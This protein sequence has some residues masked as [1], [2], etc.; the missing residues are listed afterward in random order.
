MVMVLPDLRAASEGEYYNTAAV[1]RRRRLPARQVPQAPHPAPA[2][3]LGEVLL[4]P[5]QP[6]LPGLRHRGRPG[7]RLH[8]LR[9][10]LPRGLARARPERRADRLQ[11]VGHQARP[12]QPAVEAR[13]ARR[14]RREPVLRRARTTGSAARRRVRRRRRTSTARATSSTPR[15]TSSAR[16]RPTRQG[17]DRVRDLDL[18]QIRR[19]ATTGSSTATA[20]RTPTRHR[21]LTPPRSRDTTCRPRSS[22]AARSSR[23]PALALRTSSSTARR[24]PRCS[25]PARP[26]S[27]RTSTAIADTSSTRPAST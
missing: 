23:P 26:C 5:R 25:R 24:S 15:A 16:S 10:A 11:P 3:V 27:A 4:P 2:R 19:C 9:P 1:D 6:G 7:R 13:A 14:R 22:R 20:A 12:V 21:T 8:L 17:G 18:D